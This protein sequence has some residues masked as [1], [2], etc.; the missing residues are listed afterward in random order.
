MIINPA[1]RSG[2]AR[3]LLLPILPS[4]LARGWRVDAAESRSHQD[5]IDLVHEAV[6]RGCHTAVAI[7]GGDGSA[8]AAAQA[9][10]GQVVPLGILPLGTGNDIARGLGMPLDPRIAARALVPGRTRTIDLGEVTALTT[11]ETRT[12]A[13]V[14][15]IGL[16]VF[17]LE[18]IARVPWLTGRLKYTYGG[19]RGLL[20]YEPQHV[21]VT[22]DGQEFS[23]EVMFVAITNTPTYGGGMRINPGALMDDGT[24]DV[25]IVRRTSR[26]RLIS[27]YPLVY[28]GRH[29]GLP[30]VWQ[31]RGG[32]VEIASGR[33][34]RVC[35]DGEI[36]SLTTPIRVEIVPRGLVVLTPSPGDP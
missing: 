18:A 25:C 31:A 11:G 20:S 23:D 34:M 8:T 12:F 30:E 7:G 21:R 35:I 1:A 5:L 33:P 19:L 6:N 14:A 13:C 4:L 28:A 32:R 22:V 24:L 2:R 29:V 3:G 10:R 17:A 27:R 16:D 36:T 15:G 9:L 26:P